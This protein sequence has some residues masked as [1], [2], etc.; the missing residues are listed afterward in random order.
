MLKT[1]RLR[2]ERLE[3]SRAARG[4][5][6]VRLRPDGSASLTQI[7]DGRIVSRRELSAAEAARLAKGAITIERSYGG[8]ADAA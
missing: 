2:L 3:Q 1:L 5:E 7:R 4:I 8:G 6:I